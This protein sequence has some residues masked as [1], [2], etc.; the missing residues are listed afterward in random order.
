MEWSIVGA[1]IGV[2]IWALLL[3]IAFAVDPFTPFDFPAVFVTGVIVVACFS[4][5]GFVLG[6]VWRSL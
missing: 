4:A 1:A 6:V 3:V 5:W 2:V